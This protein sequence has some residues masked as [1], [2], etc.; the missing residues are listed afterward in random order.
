MS[1]HVTGSYTI[2]YGK[3]RTHVIL[4]ITCFFKQGVAKSVRSQKPLK[5]YCSIVSLTFLRVLSLC[6]INI[7]FID[8]LLTY[9]RAVLYLLSFLYGQYTGMFSVF[10]L[11]SKTVSEGIFIAK[12]CKGSL[13]KIRD[14]GVSI[15]GITSAQLLTYERTVEAT[16]QQ[17]SI[18][19]N[20]M[21]ASE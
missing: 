15:T 14:K 9:E 2:Y 1:V 6:R 19:G 13:L 10:L 8:T 5:I 16:I 3:W 18:M 4:W 7:N 17:S 21:S 20:S 11:I 12:S